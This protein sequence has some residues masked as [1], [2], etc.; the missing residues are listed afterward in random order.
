MHAFGPARGYFGKLPS[1]GDFVG[2]GLPQGVRECF[3]RWLQEALLCSKQAL[4]AAWLPAWLN[5]P[6]W[7]FL[8]PAGICDSQAWAGVMMPSHDSVGRCFPLLMAARMASPSLDAC[9]EVHSDWFAGLEQLALS[10]LEDGFILS[11]LEAR[12]GTGSG[13]ARPAGVPPPARCVWRDALVTDRSSVDVAEA[14][15]GWWTD[16]SAQI[17]P[18]LAVCDGL[19]SAERFAA[20]LDGCW[21]KY[22]W[23]LDVQTRFI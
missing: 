10:A 18:A 20:L 5:A 12:L 16:G 8:V 19:P 4:G 13:A 17:P 1:H 9:L 7:R 23:R 15:G 2:H 22:G 6:L 14:R 11:D 21:E 3:D